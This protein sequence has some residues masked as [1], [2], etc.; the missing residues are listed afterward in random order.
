MLHRQIW[1]TLSTIDC[2]A[3]V[4]KKGN[5]DYLKWSFAWS[6]LKK[7]FPN[8]SYKFSDR[9]FPDGTVEVTCKLTIHQGEE[10]AMHEMWLP[11]MDFR[12]KPIQQPDA[13]AINT[14]KMRCLVKTISLFG[15]G[16]TI[17]GGHVELAPEAPLVAS[18]PIT[19]A[20]VTT[21][22]KMLKE[23]DADLERFL[24]YFGAST[25]DQLPADRWENMIGM[26]QEKIDA[27]QRS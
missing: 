27:N 14:T 12:N 2:S 13:F 6:Q 21:I 4:E 11:C 17:Y 23:S 16:T 3:H 18:K 26:L 22:K 15:L 8:V 25:L 5:L 24:N 9:T 1:D 19:K 10:K 20:R 7:Y